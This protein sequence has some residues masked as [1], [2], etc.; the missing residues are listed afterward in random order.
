MDERQDLT[1]FPDHGS[2]AEEQQPGLP[3]AGEDPSLNA[4]R[5]AFGAVSDFGV[6]EEADDQIGEPGETAGREGE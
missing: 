5:D 2:H 1:P 3:G 6:R 4:G